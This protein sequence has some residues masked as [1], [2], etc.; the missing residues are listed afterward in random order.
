MAFNGDAVYFTDQNLI[1][2]QNDMGNHD[3]QS[4][5]E[6]ENKF[7]HFIRET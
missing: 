6:S 4:F 3:Q 2:A 7:M 5:A 1:N